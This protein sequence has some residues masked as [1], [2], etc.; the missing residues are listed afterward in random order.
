MSKQNE[1]LVKFGEGIPLDLQGSVLLHLEMELR[2]AGVEAEVY[3][4]TKP[5]DSKVRQLMTLEKRASL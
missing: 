5:D 1:V 4:H 2:E 3:K